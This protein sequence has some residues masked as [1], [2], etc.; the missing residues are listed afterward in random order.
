MS[1]KIRKKRLMLVNKNLNVEKQKQP[2]MKES[3]NKQMLKTESAY[4]LKLKESDSNFEG[5]N[6]KLKNEREVDAWQRKKN[7]GDIKRG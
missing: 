1:L 2:N 6:K 5:E 7:A 4:D 3:G